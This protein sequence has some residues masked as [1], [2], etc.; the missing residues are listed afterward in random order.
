MS[1]EFDSIEHSEKVTQHSNC[2]VFKA[3]NVLNDED[4]DGEHLTSANKE[5]IKKNLRQEIVVNPKDAIFFMGDKVVLRRFISNQ[6]T[7]KHI[8]IEQRF[9]SLPKEELEI[10]RRSHFQDI[11]TERVVIQSLIKD[12]LENELNFERIDYSFFEKNYIKIIQKSF[13]NYLVKQ[14]NEEEAVLLALGNMILREYWL[15]LHRLMAD[16]LLDLFSQKNQAA[17]KFLKSYSGE[18]AFE[19][20]NIKYRLPEIIDE[21]GKK[22]NSVNIFSLIMQYKKG[23]EVLAQKRS[24]CSLL[25]SKNSELDLDI[26][27]YSEDIKVLTLLFDSI[28]EEILDFINDEKKLNDELKELRLGFK[29]LLND[30]DRARIQS[31]ISN[32]MIAVKK[33]S[34]KQEEAISRK[35][36]SELQIKQLASKIDKLRLE[37][38][39]NNKKMR[40]E[41]EKVN[42]FLV[43]LEETNEKYETVLKAVSL[44]LMKKKILIKGE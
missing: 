11:E 41:N 36:K 18:I 39:Q 33:L 21:S 29:E 26:K 16:T 4:Y 6:D 31:E 13:Y 19:S 38:N 34:L 1:T 2:I 44:A 27:K 9:G 7:S 30:L 3:H 12:C 20:D 35:K 15:F 5:F 43:T 22:W 25:I 28:D 32:K 8:K 17:E 10:I 40:D 42:S 14:F 23:Q 24:C 37:I